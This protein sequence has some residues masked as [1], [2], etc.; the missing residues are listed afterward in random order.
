MSRDALRIYFDEVEQ[1][2]LV[3]PNIYV[4]QFNAAILTP[5]RGNLR[6]RNP[7]QRQMPAGNP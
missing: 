5:E 6:L 1:Q 2:L 4:E 7:L 3:L